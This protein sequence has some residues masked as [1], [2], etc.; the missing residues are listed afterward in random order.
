MSN[1]LNTNQDFRPIPELNDLNR[2]FWEAC[3][4]KKLIFQCC[5]VCEHIRY[6]IAEF[7]PKCLTSEHRWVPVSGH[8]EVYS[9]VV[10]HRAYHPA[11][12][13]RVPYNIAWLR[14]EEGIFMI[15]NVVGLESQSDIQIGMKVSVDFKEIEGDLSISL[16]VFRAAKE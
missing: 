3:K 14:L 5:D 10:F 1:F 8:A 4:Q 7:C 6:P 12:V 11:F 9:F 13:D 16:P 2:P 15:S